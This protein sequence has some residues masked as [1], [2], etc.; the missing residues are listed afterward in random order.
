MKAVEMQI[1]VMPRPDLRMELL[2]ILLLFVCI[3][4]VVLAED[5]LDQLGAINIHC[6]PFIV[7]ERE[8]ISHISLS[9]EHQALEENVKGVGRVKRETHNADE[10]CWGRHVHKEGLLHIKQFE[11]KA[12]IRIVGD[13]VGATG[14][15]AL[16]V[17]AGGFNGSDG[18]LP[19]MP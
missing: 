9:E 7:V 4:N 11:A 17:A 10:E 14:L 6:L 13:E 8:V 19:P 1:S 2:Q 12:F 5:G 18:F 3:R 15:A 16:I